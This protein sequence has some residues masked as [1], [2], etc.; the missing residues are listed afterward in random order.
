VDG[1]SDVSVVEKVGAQFDLH[2]LVLEDIVV[3]SQRPKME[4][5]ED[6][7]FIV[8]RMLRYDRAANDVI[9]EQVTMILRKNFLITFQETIGDVFDQIRD[10]LRTNKGRARKMGADYLVYSLIDAIVDHY[11]TI[12]DNYGERIETLEEELLY[13]PEH[14]T[15]AKIHEFKREL[16]LLRKC[17][18][19]MRELANAMIRSESKLITESTKVYLRD[20]YDHTIQIIDTIESLRDIVASLMEIYLSN[21]NTRLNAVMKVLTIIA[22]IFMPLSF[23]T[24]VYGMNFKRMPEIELDSYWMYP[25]GF[26]AIIV[27]VGVGMLF[28][29]KRQKWL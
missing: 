20:V 27:V 29:F 26:W 3:P 14:H 25:V 19:P 8:A 17:V 13:D 2:P 1:L 6:Y 10:R 28:I 9:N 21:I 7:L 15:L 23:F 4:D 11:F 24:G 5:Y 12:L 16:T 18:W 22:T